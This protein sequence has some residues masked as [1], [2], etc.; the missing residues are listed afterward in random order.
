MN[1]FNLIA[2]AGGSGNGLYIWKKCEWEGAKPVT[3]PVIHTATVSSNV[4]KVTSDDV[5][6]STVPTVTT[7]AYANYIDSRDSADSKAVIDFLTMFK[8]GSFGF[9]II[10]N[11]MLTYVEEIGYANTMGVTRVEHYNNENALK[12]TTYQ[13]VLTSGKTDTLTYYG[14]IIKPAN[15]GDFIGY[16]VSDKEDAYP[17]GGEQG[18]FYYERY[19]PIETDIFNSTHCLVGSFTP[20]SNQTQVTIT[21]NFDA[22]T[23]FSFVFAEKGTPAGLIEMLT[24]YATTG[25]YPSGPA[26]IYK[27]F[28]TYLGYDSGYQNSSYGTRN[29]TVLYGAGR[30]FVA[31][32]KYN[33]VILA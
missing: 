29:T 21:H 25:N 8:R 9:N 4:L 20:T 19:T 26:Y 2:G 13:S 16:V 1:V 18:G 11:T 30:P 6:F 15:I 27:Y 14:T 32:T 23:K 24:A 31:G 7:T 3:N 10:N 22:I 17:D 33:Y 12:V 5:D 28:S